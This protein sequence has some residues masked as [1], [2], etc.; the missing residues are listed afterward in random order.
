MSEPDGGHDM[1]AMHL[2]LIGEVGLPEK[3]ARPEARIV[4]EKSEL[5]LGGDAIC[6]DSQIFFIGKIGRQDGDSRLALRDDLRGQ[7]F[8]P[9]FAAR[10]QQQIVVRR[11]FSRED[12]ADAA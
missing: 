9:V 2:F 4:Y 7:R 6:H 8:K 5:R 11:K 10:N 1:Q 3:A 12:R